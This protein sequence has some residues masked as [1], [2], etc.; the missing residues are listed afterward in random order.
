MYLLDTDI[1]SFAVR[2]DEQVLARFEEQGASPILVSTITL[3][4]LAYGIERSRARARLEA[5]YSVLL[6]LLTALPV[7]EGVA[8]RAAEVRAALESSGRPAGPIDPLIAATAL[9]HG[10]TLVTHNTKHFARVPA[11]A[12]EDWKA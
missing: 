5:A 8:L 3:Y 10:L 7:D 4:E 11:L 6:P 12:V 9:V 1:V 2:G